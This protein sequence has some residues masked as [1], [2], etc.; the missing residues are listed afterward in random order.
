MS[1]TRWY[2]GRQMLAFVLE[3]C[4]LADPAL[5]KGITGPAKLLGPE[6]AG[7]APFCVER[8][9]IV[10]RYPELIAATA[11]RPPQGAPDNELVAFLRM[12]AECHPDDLEVALREL[13]ARKNLR[14][15]QIVAAVT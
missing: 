11:K 14:R 3:R 1:L 12:W 15:R 13:E 2:P 8:L 4:A 7:A 5:L 6:E 9:A 10:N